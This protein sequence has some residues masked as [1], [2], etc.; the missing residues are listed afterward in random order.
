MSWL[1]QGLGVLRWG[2][3]REEVLRRFPHARA[4]ASV[5]GRNPA[6]GEAFV[7]PEGLEVPSF[8]EPKPGV[9]VNASL[10]FREDRLACIS[11][12]TSCHAEPTDD[13]ALLDLTGQLVLQ[14]AELVAAYL[15]VGPVRSDVAVQG[16][17]VDGV[18]VRLYLDC[19]D[20]EFELSV[21]E[22]GEHAARR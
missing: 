6:T 7:I 18:D 20:F 1:A 2:A 10:E 13:P 21:S 9:R 19:D 17:E 15:Q 16:W 12:A 8:F 5:R 14:E 22:V 4:R 11:L 3:T